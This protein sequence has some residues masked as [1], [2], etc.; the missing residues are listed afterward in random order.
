MN[1]TELAVRDSSGLSRR[2]V[3]RGAAWSVPVVS[4]AATAPAFAASCLSTAMSTMNLSSKLGSNGTT[5]KVSSGLAGGMTVG[6]WNLAADD[7][8]QMPAGWLEF[9][10]QPRGAGG[11]A[12]P[13]V[14]QDITFLFSSA[15]SELSFELADID[16]NG[17]R[18]QN[19]SINYN[20]WDAIAI[21][22]TTASYDVT[23]LGASLTGLGTIANPWRQE[24]FTLNPPASNAAATNRLALTFNGPVT[25]FKFRYWSIQGRSG[26]TGTQAVWIGNMTYKA[27]CT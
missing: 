6:Q 26:Y 2:T 15:V 23:T 13:T 11:N 5:V 24:T 27:S 21:H 9:E 18:N 17:T 12:N 22:G 25:T 8:S 3:V 20:Y 7:T 19:N 16:T 4:M 14:Y 10:N 1:N